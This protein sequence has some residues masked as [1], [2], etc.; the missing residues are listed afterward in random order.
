MLCTGFLWP[1]NRK[2]GRARTTGNSVLT[3]ERKHIFRTRYF[4]APADREK[5]ELHGWYSAFALGK[6]T[7]SGAVHANKI[8][9]S[10]DVFSS[11]RQYTMEVHFRKW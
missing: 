5:H 6:L 1:G 3:L 4:C 10:E 9:C 8:A 11:L 2:K 7:T